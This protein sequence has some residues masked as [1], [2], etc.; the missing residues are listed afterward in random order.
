MRTV[1]TPQ[2]LRDV[3]DILTHIAADDPGAAS[4]LNERLLHLVET[5]LPTQPHLGRPG[6]VAG[7]RELIVHR[8]Y[9]LAYRVTT[10]HLEILAF[11]HS[12]RLWPEDL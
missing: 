11:R 8:N 2:A 10:A 4:A 6:R 12:A 7:T 1:W 5:T 3:T 9:I